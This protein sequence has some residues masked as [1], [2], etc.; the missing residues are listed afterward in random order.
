[1]PSNQ[2]LKRKHLDAELMGSSYR[3]RCALEIETDQLCRDCLKIDFSAILHGDAATLQHD[4]RSGVFIANLG[5]R[6]NDALERSCPLCHLFYHMRVLAPRLSDSHEYHLRAYSA[7]NH[8]NSMRMDGCPERLATKDLPC[9]AI[10]SSGSTTAAVPQNEIKFLYCHSASYD[11]KRIFIP[12]PISASVDFSGVIEI[13]RYCKAKH[14]NLCHDS[15]PTVPGMKLI[16]CYKTAKSASAIR[17]E[18]MAST[19]HPYVALSYVWGNLNDNNSGS[20]A[21]DDEPLPKVVLDAM[22]ATKEMGYQYLWIDKYCIDQTNHGERDFQMNHMD[23]IY[24][25]AEVT[26]VAASGK[27]ANSGLAGVGDTPRIAQQSLSIGNIQLISN[28]HVPQVTIESSTWYTRAWTF[29]EGILPRRRLVFTPYEVYF[30]CESMYWRES[31]GADLDELHSHGRLLKCFIPGIFTGRSSTAGKTE[32]SCYKRLKRFDCFV[33]NYSTKAFSHDFGK[34]DSLQA[35]QGIMNHFRQ[36]KLPVYQSWGVPFT[37]SSDHS[38]ESS[39]SFVASLLWRHTTTKLSH[40]NK[41]QRRDAFPSWSWAGWAGEVTFPVRHPAKDENFASKVA[42]LVLEAGQ[43]M[44]KPVEMSSSLVVSTPQIEQYRILKLRALVL[45]QETLG[46]C[47]KRTNESWDMPNVRLGDSGFKAVIYLSDGPVTTRNFQFLFVSGKF[48]F[49]LLA[50]ES[51][52]GQGTKRRPYTWFMI[53]E[54][55][56]DFAYRVGSMVVKDSLEAFKLKFT[57]EER[58]IV[59]R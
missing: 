23:V 21:E 20:K 17:L 14:R 1:M 31:W 50:T 37:W 35:F 33:S 38:S 11:H 28:M 5:H 13:M 52:G 32:R 16:D 47:V 7:I 19:R 12:R 45:L 58:Q 56:G 46:F 25:G 2:H 27:D 43:G 54:P 3:S 41:P 6:L 4:R 42:N 29:Q 8:F 10:V 22:T 55:H 40:T 26:I 48:D 30:E 49:V 53:T 59:L 51:I 57:L 24:R 34:V 9:L 44:E 15:R 39:G 36:S 18:P